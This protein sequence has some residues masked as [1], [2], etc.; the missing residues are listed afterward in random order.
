MTPAFPT[1]RAS[2]LRRTPGIRVAEPAFDLA[3]CREWKDG[4]VNRLTNGVAAL[5]KKARV[6]TVEGTARFRDGKTV[7]VDTPLGLQVI[8]AENVI[9]ATGHEPVALPA[10]PFG[11]RVISSTEALALDAPPER[12]AVV[13]AGYIG[14]ISEERRVGKECV[15]TCRS[16]WWTYHYK[17]TE[18]QQYT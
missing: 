5:L 7:E 6:K 13:G 11:G 1:R 3:A 4:I 8:R 15:G 2:D 16:R 18:L 14:L 17:K 9:V 12:L 10:L